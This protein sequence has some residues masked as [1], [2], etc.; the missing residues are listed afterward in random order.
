VT[1]LDDLAAA[2]DSI[3]Y[4][5]AGMADLLSSS[6]SPERQQEWPEGL[7]AALL[8]LGEGVVELRQDLHVHPVAELRITV[9][10]SR[11]S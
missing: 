1:R 7:R 9:R 8:A 10:R 5:M 3:G 6:P 2:V 4:G 11:A